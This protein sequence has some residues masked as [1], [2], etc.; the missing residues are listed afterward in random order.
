[1]LTLI[2]SIV[3]VLLLSLIEVLVLSPVEVRKHTPLL[4]TLF[5][6]HDIST[7]QALA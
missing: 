2:L 1:M 6:Q 7:F 5:K 4:F 3:E